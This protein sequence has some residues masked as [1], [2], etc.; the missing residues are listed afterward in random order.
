MADGTPYSQAGDPREVMRGRAMNAQQYGVVAICVLINMIDGYDILAL[1]QAGAALKREWGMSDALLGTLLSMNLVGMALGALLI[2]V[3]M[4]MT[5]GVTVGMLST[6]IPSHTIPGLGKVSGTAW[7]LTD[8][9]LGEPLTPPGGACSGTT[10]VQEWEGRSAGP[11]GQCAARHQRRH[12]RQALASDLPGSFHPPSVVCAPC[13]RDPGIQQLFG[14][15]LCR[16][17]GAE[18]HG[19]RWLLL[20]RRGGVRAVHAGAAAVQHVWVARA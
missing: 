11:L 12:P 15:A 10:A 18:G 17:H 16:R 14:W 2:G 9:F 5:H 8:M 6:Y 7:S 13:R 4:A 19:Q 1:A 20:W 3:H